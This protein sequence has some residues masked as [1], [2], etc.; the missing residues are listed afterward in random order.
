MNGDVSIAGLLAAAASGAL[1][2]WASG[3]IFGAVVGGMVAG[4][5]LAVLVSR[6]VDDD[7]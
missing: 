2:G 5:I 6:A 4:G 3:G 7:E 1:V